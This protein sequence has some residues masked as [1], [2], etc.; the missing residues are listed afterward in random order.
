MV[1]TLLQGNGQT[2]SRLCDGSSGFFDDR[3][4]FGVEWYCLDHHW[5]RL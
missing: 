1:N 2:S 3:K 5:I 4:G